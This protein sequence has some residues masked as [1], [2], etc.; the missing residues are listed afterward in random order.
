MKILISTF[1]NIRYMRPNFIPLSTCFSDPKYFHNNKGVSC[2]FKDKNGVW[3]GIRFEAFMPGDACEGLCR[4]PSG[5]KES[6]GNC[7]FLQTYY[8][9]LCSYDFNDIMRRLEKI[10]N[11]VKTYE[12][13]EEDPVIVLLVYEA[14]TNPCSERWPLKKWFADHNYQLEEFNREKV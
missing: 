4:G 6:K 12:G 14:Q 7:K 10:A 3:N 1:Y 8:N 5:C 9:Q 11:Q 2:Q 13:F